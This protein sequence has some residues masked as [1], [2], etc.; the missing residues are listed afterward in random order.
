MTPNACPISH[1]KWIGVDIP[2]NPAPGA[3]GRLFGKDKFGFESGAEFIH[4]S[5]TVLNEFMKEHNFEGEELFTWAHGDGGVSDQ[6]APSGHIGMYYLGKEKK[7]YRYDEV[8]GDLKKMQEVL[9]ELAESAAGMTGSGNPINSMS[10]LQA[11]RNAGVAERVLGM[12]EAGY[13]NTVGGTLDKINLSRIATCERNWEDEGEGDFRVKNSTMHETII[14]ALAKDIDVQLT[15]VVRSVTR[16]AHGVEVTIRGKTEP[17]RALAAVVSVSMSAL[18]RKIIAFEPP[19]NLRQSNAIKSVS[20]EP[21]MKI[22]VKFTQRKWPANVHGMVCADSFAPELWFQDFKAP[23][24]TMVFYCT[25]FFMSDMARRVAE[26]KK[27]QMFESLLDQLD[28]MF[29][30]RTRDHYCGGCMVD[31]GKVPYI[32]GAYSVPG[33]NEMHNARH[34]LAE[35]IGGRIFFAGEA[36]HPDA[37]MTAHAAMLTGE[38]AALGA[39]DVVVNERARDIVKISNAATNIRSRL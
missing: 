11:L 6:P 7:L 21:G 3:Q 14:P 26:L 15:S 1:Q 13:A 20:C 36:T 23:D 38:R 4:G 19:L 16:T 37:Y 33:M 30:L 18:Q 29:N 31:W 17:I 12:A 10:L 9:L 32:W 8:D 25:A 28:E 2:T 35:P 5:K 24:G 39:M 34:I 22:L 27:N